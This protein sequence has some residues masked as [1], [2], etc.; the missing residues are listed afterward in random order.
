MTKA[1]FI[2]ARIEP[3]FAKMID[4]TAEE[5]KVD[6]STALKEL[7]K[8]GRQ[9]LLENRAIELYRNGRISVD[10]AAEMLS[11]TVSETMKLFAAAGLKSE[12]TFEEYSSGLRLLMKR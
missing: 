11:M 8:H 5:E 6:K 9:K 1:K 7:I 12:E 4:E 10:K 2:G 3:E